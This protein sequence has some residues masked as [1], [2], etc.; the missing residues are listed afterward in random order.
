MRYF[1]LE[2][3]RQYGR[4]KLFEAKQASAARDRHF[5]HYKNI[6]SGLWHVS[7]SA[8]EVETQR[9]KSIQV[10]VENLRAAFEWGLQNYVQDALDLA[11]NI[12]LTISMIGG[13][14]EA[15]TILTLAMEKFRALPPVEGNEK[16]VRNEIYA[17]GCFSLGT[18]LQFTNEIV[19]SRS[20]LQEAIA[21]ARELGDKLLL[22]LCLDMYANASAMIQADDTVA[23]AKEGLEIFR[24]I[25]Y[26][27]GMA[28]S[29][30]NLARWESIHGNFQE[31]EKY[32][33]LMTSIMENGT[34]SY[35]S[36]FLNMG[37]GM[38][39]RAQGR[40]DLARRYFDESLRVFKQIGH[41]GM[42]AIS[43][44]EIAHTQRAQGNYTEAKKTYHETIKIL[45]DYGNRPAVA[46]Q[47]EC[48]AMIAIVEEE[49]E[50]AAQL[51][52]AAEAL[53]E[54]TG[55]KR[56]DEEE[57]EFV[58]FMSRLRLMLSETEFNEFWVEGKSMTMERAVWLATS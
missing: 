45:Q 51:F 42:T 28:M 47:L 23:A 58:Q 2:T 25:N 20:V 16:R 36:G 1:M 11:T 38:G 30:G 7:Y 9:V 53:R 24:E 39:A 41:K 37:M 44:S 8:S 49:P 57:V 55:H 43:T 50:R 48:F 35:Q 32:V 26:R 17:H 54:T 6:S 40:F 3:I 33:A 29:Y 18:L 14:I 46:H 13:Q 15:I 5:I 34:V 19:S 27:G 52:A 12:A 4:E 31:A 22:G 56:T 21:I 10:E